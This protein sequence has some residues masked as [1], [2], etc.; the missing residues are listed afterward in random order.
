MNDRAYGGWAGRCR[1]GFLPGRAGRPPG[2]G[3]GPARVDHVLPTRGRPAPARPSPGRG[4]AGRRVTRRP[5]TAYR[6][7]APAARR[8]PVRPKRG[9]APRPVRHRPPRRGRGR[10]RPRGPAVEGGRVRGGGVAPPPH[11]GPGRLGPG[12]GAD[13]AKCLVPAG[14]WR[15]AA[16]G[17][18]TGGGTRS[19]AAQGRVANRPGAGS[20]AARRRS[21][22]RIRRAAVHDGPE[23]AGQGRCYEAPR[24]GSRGARARTLR[25]ASAPRGRTD[26]FPGGFPYGSRACGGRERRGRAR[27]PGAP[28]SMGRGICGTAGAGGRPGDGR[29]P[30]GAMYAYGGE[31]EACRAGG[32]F[33]RN[34]SRR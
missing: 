3:G 11:R 32:H 16:M 15:H 29:R 2:A 5:R 25:P 20:G 9:P 19:H 24:A 18:R 14:P 23:V 8:P 31:G 21:A 10:A 6:W 26:S 28:G 27:V 33:R 7:E 1:D 22:P 30:Y 13:G 34:W 12:P 4:G 17:P